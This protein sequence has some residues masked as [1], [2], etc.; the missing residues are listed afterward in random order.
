MA[1][2]VETDTAPEQA[3]PGRSSRLILWLIL[4]S[5]GILFLTLFLV[6]T[7]IKQ[8]IPALETRLA[9][10]QETLASTPPVPP[11]QQ[12]LTANLLDLRGQEQVLE[13]VRDNL[14]A[15]H[16]N[17]PA[18]MAAIA[19]YDPAQMSVTGLTQTDSQVIINGQA[20]D[21]A[22]VIAYADSLRQSEQFNQ[23]TVQSITLQTLPTS[24]PA[25]TP[26][27]ATTPDPAIPTLPPPTPSP[28]VKVAAFVILVELKAQ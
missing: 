14:T 15:Q 12:T 16:I 24:T 1:R 3:A 18:A 11:E 5:L 19:S 13:S 22:V 4:V 23:V 10:V 20:N 7:T 26:T 17:W 25:P 21:E 2:S 28:P 8:D 27:L 6:S 9:E